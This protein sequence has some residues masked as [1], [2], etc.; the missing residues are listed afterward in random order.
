M[1][2][3]LLFIDGSVDVSSKTGFG[4]WLVVSE[5]VPSPETLKKQVK[6]KRFEQTSSTKLELQTLMWVLKEIPEDGNRVIIYTDSQN[7]ISLNS[8]RERLEK[9][10]YHSRNNRQINN[11]DLYIEFFRL[12]DRFD[13]E[14]VK[15][16]GHQPT[17]HKD[18]IHRLFTMV[19]RA[20]RNALRKEKKF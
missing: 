12:M 16:Q 3:I 10:N 18:E 5:P 6:V 4:A 9:N 7:I 8:R 20:S 13:C 15:V 1:N 14:F 17:R 19:D 11:S 2:K